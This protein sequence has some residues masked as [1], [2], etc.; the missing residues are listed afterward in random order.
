MEKRDAINHTSGVLPRLKQNK[1]LLFTVLASFIANFLLIQMPFV[2]QYL[3]L[4]PLKKQE[5]LVVFVA[6]FPVLLIDWT[7]HRLMLYFQ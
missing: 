5:W 3:G 1:I 7:L 4:Q 2:G 6:A